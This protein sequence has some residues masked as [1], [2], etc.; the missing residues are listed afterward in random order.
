[1]LRYVVWRTLRN[2]QRQR[3]SSREICSR[4]FLR[5][6][7][8]GVRLPMFWRSSHPCQYQKDEPARNVSGRTRSA[9]RADLCPGRRTLGGLLRTSYLADH[10]TRID[11][12]CRL[13]GSVEITSI[14]A[15]AQ[16]PL[17]IERP[18]GAANCRFTITRGWV[19]H[20]LRNDRST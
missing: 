5:N 6:V 2:A 9:Q 8:S 4:V 3:W 7:L 13:V 10:C 16:T 17:G 19:S 11:T 1:M 18:T 20:F 15:A 12:R 14:L